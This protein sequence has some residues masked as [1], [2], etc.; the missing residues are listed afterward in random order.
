MAK[1]N[2]AFEKKN[3]DLAKKKKQ[4]EKRA[5]KQQQRKSDTPDGSKPPA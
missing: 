2:Y 1:P 4:D 3:R 5:K